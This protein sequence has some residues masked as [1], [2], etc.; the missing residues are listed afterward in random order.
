[1]CEMRE[2][3]SERIQSQAEVGGKRP[4]ISR[5]LFLALTGAAALAPRPSWAKEGFPRLLDHIILG[6]SDLDAGIA[7][8]EEQTGVRAT[9]G[10]AHPGRGTMNA[11]I[12]LGE[13]HY[14]EIMAPNPKATGTQPSAV[15]EIATLKSLTSPRVIT[16]AAHPKDIAGLAKTLH[17]SRVAIVGPTPGSRIRPDG[18]VLSWKT[19]VLADDR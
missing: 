13:R 12:S 17:D 15:E 7:F 8:V 9:L 18:R 19:L 10:G 16:W 4:L 11:L 2:S 1:M 6:C 3:S 14:L 5:R